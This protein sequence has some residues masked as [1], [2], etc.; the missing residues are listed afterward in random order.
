MQAIEAPEFDECAEL[1]DFS[2][3]AYSGKEIT[4]RLKN[5]GDTV[6]SAILPGVRH[7]FHISGDTVFITCSESRFTRINYHGA[8]EHT[9][10]G[11]TISRQFGVSGRAF[12]CD[13][14]YGYGRCIAGAV[15]RGTLVM[16]MGDTIADVVL[17]RTILHYNVATDR[18]HA[19]NDS[20]VTKRTVTRY[21]WISPGSVFPLATASVTHD[22]IGEKAISPVS[23]CL[24]S[25]PSFQPDSKSSAS[26][27]AGG[28]N[29]NGTASNKAYDLFRHITVNQTDKNVDV[30]VTVARECDVAIMLC[31]LY[32]RVFALRR[33]VNARSDMAANHVFDGS[34]LPPGEY[35]ITITAG[36]Q[37][38][39]KKFILR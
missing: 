1:W 35:I 34:G 11:S 17:H 30:T 10:S 37:R 6:I 28:Q 3:A 4:V 31:D 9:L 22:T 20:L 27:S 5:W 33:S 39:N 14:L 21:S 25:A 24:M 23:L 19:D 8:I 13:S 29:D 12:S 2:G 15:G 16:H 38:T 26:R 18:T 7:D 36:H 32:G